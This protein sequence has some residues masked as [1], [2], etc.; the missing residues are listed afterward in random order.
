M[1][2]AIK[3]NQAASALYMSKGETTMDR[4][5]P[6]DF[7][8]FYR[9]LLR[10]HGEHLTEAD[11]EAVLHTEHINSPVITRTSLKSQ[12]LFKAKTPEAAWAKVRLMRA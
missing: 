6:L 10:E 9:V 1:K 5:S 4:D 3:V 11:Q 7:A 2:R 8:T 12:I